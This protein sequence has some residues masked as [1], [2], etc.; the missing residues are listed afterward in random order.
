MSLSI[1][2]AKHQAYLAMPLEDEIVEWLKV[3]EVGKDGQ[4]RAQH[5]NQGNGWAIKSAARE[6]AGEPS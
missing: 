1:R 5:Q 2:T 4:H 3:Q 6:R